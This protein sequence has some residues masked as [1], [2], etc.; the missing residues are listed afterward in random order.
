MEIRKQ[1][2]LGF[3]IYTQSAYST[4]SMA[5]KALGIALWYLVPEVKLSAF[6]LCAHSSEILMKLL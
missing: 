2:V 6:M 4:V 5:Y 1:E 3:R